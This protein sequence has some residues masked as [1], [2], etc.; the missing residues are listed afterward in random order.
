[1]TNRIYVGD[2]GTAFILEVVDQDGDIVNL[3]GLT[4]E[5]LF[6]RPDGTVLTKTASLV[7]DG[8]DG[9]MRYLSVDGFLSQAGRWWSQGK[10]TSGGNVWYTN[11]GVFQV[12]D[13]LG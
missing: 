8:S 10:I 4:I 1:M 2:I 13:P 3:A 6:E 5:I 7:N 12:Y 11:D 9:L